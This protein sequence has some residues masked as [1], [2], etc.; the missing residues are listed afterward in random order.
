MT[1]GKKRGVGLGGSY[2][3]GRGATVT[4]SVASTEIHVAMGVFLE[5]SAVASACYRIIK[6]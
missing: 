1:D 3:H 6:L 5:I 4:Q 2:V